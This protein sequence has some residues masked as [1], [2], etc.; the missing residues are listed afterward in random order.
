[1][2]KTLNYP[3]Q[4]SRTYEPFSF[5]SKDRSD[6]IEAPDPGKGSNQPFI[7]ERSRGKA[8]FTGRNVICQYFGRQ[9]TAFLLQDLT[10]D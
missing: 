9:C 2:F 10:N 5:G 3:V 8:N 1:M 7:T 4:D 6:K